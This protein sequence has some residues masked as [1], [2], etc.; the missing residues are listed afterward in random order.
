MG[1]LV[2]L[3]LFVL[4]CMAL[5][6]PYGRRLLG[7]MALVAGTLIAGI[8]TFIYVTNRQADRAEAEA[9]AEA[10]RKPPEPCT[11]P[12]GCEPTAAELEARLAQPTHEQRSP[13]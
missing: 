1:Y 5:M 3:G 8:A 6:H 11:Y 4:F 7:V 13:P 10:A 9:A 2:A 12:Q